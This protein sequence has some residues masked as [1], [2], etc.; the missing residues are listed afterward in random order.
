MA[1]RNNIKSAL[2]KVSDS[3]KTDKEKEVEQLESDNQKLKGEIQAT[4]AT[5]YD[6][7]A[8][9]KVKDKTKRVPFTMMLRPDIKERLK[10]ISHN[11]DVSIS[12]I[13]EDILKERFDM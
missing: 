10:I 9:K 4:I 6:L 13:V 8:K 11:N 7:S 12:Q 1:K 5:K 3:F 2:D